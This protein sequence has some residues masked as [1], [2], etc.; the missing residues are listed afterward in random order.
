MGIFLLILVL[1]SLSLVYAQGVCS[2]E[3]VIFAQVLL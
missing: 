2:F 3:S 1:V